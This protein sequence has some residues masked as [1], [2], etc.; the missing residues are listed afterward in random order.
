MDVVVVK[1]RTGSRRRL[2]V[3]KLNSS[4]PL[5]VELFYGV[6]VGSAV[7]SLHFNVS[8]TTLILQILWILAVL[9]DWFLYHKYIVD[10][11]SQAV[12]YSFRSLLIEFGILTSWYLG[13]D[14]LSREEAP[15]SIFFRWAACFYL[16]KVLA[17]VGFYSKHSQLF[18]RRM[19]YD[20][21]WL[22]PV[23]LGLLFG[24][25]PNLCLGLAFSIYSVSTAFVLGIWWFVTKRWPTKNQTSLSR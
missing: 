13:F 6:V 18:S 20:C 12:S 22:V 25:M 1:I 23:V 21:L 16:I 24:L 7:A 17:G 10:N 2:T 9:E 19:L 3:I 4:N 5:F 15:S 11:E 14:S 8:L